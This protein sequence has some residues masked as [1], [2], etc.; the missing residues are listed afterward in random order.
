MTGI[1]SR[2]SISLSIPIRVDDPAA[3]TTAEQ[4]GSW[5]FFCFLRQN[6]LM[7]SFTN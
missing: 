2:G 3:T 5:R 7:A 1:S 4:Q 6:I